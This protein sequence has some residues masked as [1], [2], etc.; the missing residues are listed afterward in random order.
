MKSAVLGALV[1][2]G[3]VIATLVGLPG[4]HQ[5]LAER[6]GPDEV[7]AG[8]GMIALS[9]T[10]DDNRQQITLIDPLSRVMSVYHVDGKT[11]YITLKSV[12]NVTWDLQIME[13]NGV[14]PLPREVRSLVEGN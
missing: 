11:G 4:S 6:A 7:G 1:L 13:L 8:Q 10:T 12:R 3:L 14:S 9:C 5:V 2:A